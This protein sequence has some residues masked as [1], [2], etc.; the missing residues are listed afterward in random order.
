M[1]IG[2][3]RQEVIKLGQ[4]EQNP[5]DPQTTSLKVKAVKDYQFLQEIKQWQHLETKVQSEKG[6]AQVSWGRGED[7]R[8]ED[9]G[10]RT[11][12]WLGNTK[13]IINLRIHKIYHISICFILHAVNKVS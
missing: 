8:A 11:P 5:Q 9:W 7:R 3:V 1:R 2:A 12:T 6:N 4:V 13:K 10:K